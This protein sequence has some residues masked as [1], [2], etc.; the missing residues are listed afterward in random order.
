MKVLVVSNCATSAYVG[1]LKALFP[2]WDV[3]GVMTHLADQWVTSTPP[4]AAFVQFAQNCDLYLGLAPNGTRW[5]ELLPERIRRVIVPSFWFRGLQPDSFHLIGFD[6][7]LRAGGTLY[8]RIVVASFAAGLPPT[9]ACQMFNE[10]TYEAFGFLSCFD[11]DK[12]EMI[13][14]FGQHGIDLSGSMERWMASGNFVYT[15]N[16]ARIDVYMEI[17]RR[18]LVAAD[19]LA[20]SEL[21]RHDDMGVVDNLKASIGWPVYPEIAK[22]HGLEGSLL[23]RLGGAGESRSLTLGQ[24]VE[25]SF[26]ALAGKPLPELPMLTAW[27]DTIKL[28]A[29]GSR[30]SA[31]A[32]L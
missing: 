4:N 22:L 2:D 11:R 15:Y 24:F 8:S 6:S 31:D 25:A 19:L 13:A 23:W 12:R 7:V 18:A 21:E 9:L 16:H 10:A 28:L 32:C 27:V 3:R 17:L 29:G 26:K 14:R 1:G 20:A 5:G 30:S